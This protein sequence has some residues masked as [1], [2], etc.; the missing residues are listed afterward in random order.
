MGS[1]RFPLLG[2]AVVTP[3]DTHVTRCMMKFNII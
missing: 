3:V 1:I 2:A